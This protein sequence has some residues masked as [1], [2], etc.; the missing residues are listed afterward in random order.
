MNHADYTKEVLRTASAEMRPMAVNSNL[1]HAIIGLS[2]EA[3][4]LIDELKRAIFY[5]AKLDEGH[6]VEELGDMLWYLTLALHAIGISMEDLRRLNAAKLRKRYVSGFTLAEA[7][8]KRDHKEAQ[9]G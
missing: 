3:G 6:I 9:H 7:T 1:A 5:G 2:G 8:M 4:E